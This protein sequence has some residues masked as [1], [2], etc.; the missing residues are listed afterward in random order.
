MARIFG[1][2]VR[3]SDAFEK[4]VSRMGRPRVRQIREDV[5]VF[6][7]RG[8]LLG[9]ALFCGELDLIGPGRWRTVASA[10]NRTSGDGQRA[11]LKGEAKE[12]QA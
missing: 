1:H 4:S 5:I 3:L 8:I 10:K 2:V 11:Q 7:I 9:R 12:D 6:N